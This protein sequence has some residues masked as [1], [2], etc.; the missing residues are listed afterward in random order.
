MFPGV[1]LRG[2]R[3]GS[4]W[5][6]PAG[7]ERSVSALPRGRRRLRVSWPRQEIQLGMRAR[8]DFRF[9]LSHDFVP[10][11]I[12]TG[13]DLIRV[14]GPARQW[15]PYDIAGRAPRGPL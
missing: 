4:T 1:A 15:R 7:V 12:P 5:S 3:R 2:D 11:F 14:L 13:D 9:L 8:G 6:A 10:V